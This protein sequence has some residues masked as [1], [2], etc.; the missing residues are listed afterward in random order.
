MHFRARRGYDPGM[1]EDLIRF[2]DVVID[3][4]RRELRK[5]G[6]PVAVQPKVFDLVVYLARHS[7][8][9]VTKDELQDAVWPGVIVTET[10]LTRAIMKARRAVGDDSERQ[11]VIRTVHARGYRFVAALLPDAVPEAPD[12]G[13]S[14]AS[15]PVGRPAGW[16]VVGIVGLLGLA[17]A[18]ALFLLR[19]EAR[20]ETRIAVLPVEDRSGDAELAWASLG[21]MSYANRLLAEAV[22]SDTVGPRRMMDVHD[23]LPP[24]PGEDDLQQVRRSLGASHLVHAVLERDAAELK[25][26]YRVLHDR[27]A[28]AP[29]V[30]S[31][32]D[33]T[34][35][36]RQMVDSVI[37]TLPGGGARR[38][39]RSVSDDDF[40]NE[41]YAR[42]LALTLQ[43]DSGRARDYF[44]VAVRQEPALFWPRYELALSMR[45]AGELDAART[46]LDTLLAEEQSRD[47]AE[48][49][50]AAANAL[51]LVLWR[52]QDYEAAWSAYEEALSVARGDDNEKNEA[53]VLVNLGILA[54]VTGRLDDARRYLAESLAIQDRLGEPDVGSAYQSLGQVELGAGQLLL[55]RDYFTRAEAAFHGVGNRRGAA[56]AGNALARVDHRLGRILDAERHMLTALAAREALE[57]FFG[58]VASHLS[59]AEIYLDLEDPVEA[60]RHAEQAIELAGASGYTAGV[61][62]GLETRA[63]L[64]LAA[65]D[66]PAATAVLDRLEAEFPAAA[67]SPRRRLLL[68]RRAAA[69]GRLDEAT[70]VL[71]AM[72]EEAPPAARIDALQLLGSLSTNR[73]TSLRWWEQALELAEQEHEL[74]RLARVL[75][76]RAERALAEGDPAAALAD[77]ARLSEGFPEWPAL[78]R[79]QARVTTAD[80]ALE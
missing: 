57:D 34:R 38:P 70:L 20:P 31:G 41:A 76:A 14:P 12:A 1:G 15:T 42:G 69:E 16:R 23:Q 74:A 66:L 7:D 62:E 65:H 50:T 35:L 29:A 71:Q 68:A 49:R 37:V 80:A 33:P 52:Q 5:A 18:A 28:G 78:A 61:E 64:A 79:L 10:A 56:A 55:A 51:A 54:R 3:P 19:D 8:R 60:V 46:L 72:L 47:D 17:A 6:Q 11:A 21:L 39:F 53:A 27:G 73:P 26:R 48:M 63:W 30:L 9:A 2:N 45:D 36:A 67:N 75:V 40:V 25:L 77:L 59:L 58:R 43:G 44:E 24:E 32:S 4:S 22:G 13:E